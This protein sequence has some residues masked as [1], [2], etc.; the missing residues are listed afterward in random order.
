MD[1][2][3][4]IAPVGRSIIAYVYSYVSCFLG[5]LFASIVFFTVDVI[6]C[7][8]SVLDACLAVL[9]SFL[10]FVCIYFHVFNIRAN[11]K[12]LSYV[13]IIICNII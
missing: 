9:V 12:V 7:A 5:C 2:V 4:Y 1:S 13:Y 11:L 10:M 8:F 3:F 6:M